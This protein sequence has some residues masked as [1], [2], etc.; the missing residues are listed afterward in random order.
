M[1]ENATPEAPRIE[2]VEIDLGIE[3]V[4][5]VWPANERTRAA[6]EHWQDLK[7]G[8]LM[9]W[10]IY[11]HVGQAGSWSLHRDHL[12]DFTDPPADWV[13]SDAEYHDWYRD[14]ARSF[15]GQ[16]YHAVEW[17]A[18]CAG[19]GA[20]Y[21][22]F[23]AKHHDGF[24]MYDTRF[25]NFKATSEE[26][27]LGR[28]VLR[29]TFDAF[30]AKEMEVGVYF[31]KADWNHPGYWDRALPITDRFHNYDRSE[32]PGQWQSFVDFT[33]AQIDELMTRYGRVNALWLDAGW[34]RE[35]VE[36]IGMAA[37]AEAS[38]AAQPDLL[39]VDRTVH[40]PHEM[41]RTPEEV[42]PPRKMDTPW[43]SCIPMTDHWCSV[44]LD[45][46]ARPFADILRE[47][48]QVVTRGG[49]YLIGVGP[50]ATGRLSRSV[51]ERLAQLGEWLEVNGD[52]VY[53][54]RPSTLAIES[55]DLA[56]ATTS[57]GGLTYA[58]GIARQGA[59]TPEQTITLPEGFIGARRL[60]DGALPVDDTGRGA[61]VRVPA[62]DA[63][64]VV[65]VLESGGSESAVG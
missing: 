58:F 22:I 45:E 29:E 46:E 9:H 65:I 36:P 10:G 52:A 34:V 37:I 17:A 4:D 2:G 3:V 38:L 59:S 14:Q 12:G 6:L 23:T 35:P 33:Q 11:S 25:S 27:G 56:W 43:E 44:V 21:M 53:G 50:D 31:S 5:Y 20:R 60:G 28:D 19:S 55:T 39:I 15:R 13:G 30:R 18:A 26:S 49:N 16:D 61:V 54:T 57:S 47:L 1:A 62:T 51:A 42:I 40:G 48:A 41:Y 7:V 64:V 32:R 8:V 63:S 24:A